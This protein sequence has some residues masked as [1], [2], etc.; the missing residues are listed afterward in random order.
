MS[1][2]SVPVYRGF[3]PELWEMTSQLGM[4]WCGGYVRWM[5]SP[6]RKPEPANDV[7]LFPVR[8]GNEDS[9]LRFLKSEGWDVKH[10][11][12]TA[13][14]MARRD[15]LPYITWPTLQI[16]RGF[17]SGRTLTYG[18]VEDIIANFDF[19][20]VRIGLSTPETALADPL[21]LED[22]TSKRIHWKNIHCPI[23]AVMRYTKYAKRGYYA[24]PSE[25]TKLFVDWDDRGGEY[26]QRLLELLSGSELSEEEVSELEKLLRI[27]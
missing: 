17:E 14:T 1:W 3:I 26:R 25:I 5:C 27:D 2:N 23:T 19:T 9:F 7:D 4:V 13:Y 11:S 24:S 15:Q 20:V 22:E 12:D 6:T 21:F 10:E 18:S 8:K 16:I